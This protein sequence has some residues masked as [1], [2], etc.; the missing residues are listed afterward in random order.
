MKQQGSG[1]PTAQV[2]VAVVA[3]LA[4]VAGAAWLLWPRTKPTLVM[5]G[6]SVTF[7]S[8]PSIEDRL[9]GD[10]ELDI[11]AYP[12]QRSTDLVLV[13][14]QELTERTEAGGQVDT[15]SLLV[16][17][18]DVLRYRDE[19]G[20]VA[21]LI[22]LASRA[23]CAVVL[24]VPA[25]PEWSEQADLA[26][27]RAA[28]AEYNTRLAAEVDRYDNVHLATAWQE[29]VEASAPGELVDT[30]GVHPIEAGQERL[31]E[32]YQA[33]IDDHC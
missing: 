4:V 32:A 24:S 7:L 26:E 1:R 2:V 12:G 11:R 22:E 10:H 20:E 8:I 14:M 28:F 29:A 6:D 3:V 5:V 33:A 15:M 21:E 31:A 18:N 17:Y 13:A 27:L 30:D 19:P 23:E 9:G 25:P 16:G